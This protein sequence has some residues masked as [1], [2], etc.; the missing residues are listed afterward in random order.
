[1]GDSVKW[2]E[3]SKKS[4]FLLFFKAWSLHVSLTVLELAMETR[5]ALNSKR[6]NCFSLQSAGIKGIC[7]HAQHETD[8]K[9]K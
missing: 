6:Y 9:M 4:R 1:M 5:L 8:L 3:K 2:G 7:H